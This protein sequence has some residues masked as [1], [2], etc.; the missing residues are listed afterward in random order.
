MN[1]IIN[2]IPFLLSVGILFLYSC[3][4]DEDPGFDKSY[5]DVMASNLKSDLVDD[6]SI[7]PYGAI[8][9]VSPAYNLGHLPFATNAGS[10]DGL[11][12]MLDG[13]DKSLTY[14]VYCHSDGPSI[15]GAEL[16]A[17]NGFSNI[18]RLE[19]NYAAWDEVSFIDIA[20]SVAKSKIDA[21]DF[22]AI[23]DVSPIFNVMHIP[24]A[25][26]AWRSAGGTVL[27]ELIGG[28]DKTKSYLV[29]CHSDSPAMEGA[30]LM[31]DAGFQ[32][33]YRLEGNYGA[34]VDAGY[35]TE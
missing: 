31:E 1:K 18:H 15:A 26:N 24:G 20:A 22:E 28:M 7:S 32:N 12:T 16:M 34:W 21:D 33:V 5:T 4:K 29:Y 3:E 13:L 2:T 25:T 35:D 6:A 11:G 10:V 9:D 19:G 30:Q 8:F 23:F 14:L 17:K 27:S